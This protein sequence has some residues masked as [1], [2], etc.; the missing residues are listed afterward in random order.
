[1]KSEI[2]AIKTLKQKKAAMM[3]AFVIGNN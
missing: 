1:M 2:R 3:A